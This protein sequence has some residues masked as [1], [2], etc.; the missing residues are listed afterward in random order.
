MIKWKVLWCCISMSLLAASCAP[1][2]L[3]VLVPDPDGSVGKVTVSTAG[4]SV[5]LDQANQSTAIRSP[6]SA[7]GQP[8]PMDRADVEKIFEPVLANQPLAPVHFILHFHSDSIELLPESVQSFPRIV[9]EIRQRMPSRVSVVG[10]TDTRG[11]K[12]YNLEL[13]MRRAREVKR[14]LTEM[15]IDAASIDV[16]SHGEENPLVQT[17]DD[18]SNAENRR[19][20]VVVR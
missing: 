14:R 3:V 7:P 8:V 9:E 10:H 20:E 4:G 2:G 13:S 16:S 1:K 19:V 11:D 5:E 17:G 15:G 18:V 6:D 12:D